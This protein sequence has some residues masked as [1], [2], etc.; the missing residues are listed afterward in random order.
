[1]C[2]DIRAGAKQIIPCDIFSREKILDTGELSAH[3]LHRRKRSVDGRVEGW[4][5][6][7]E[8]ANRFPEAAV[9][10]EAFVEERVKHQ[11]RL[12]VCV[13]VMVEE[14]GQNIRGRDRLP[15]ECEHLTD[16]HEHDGDVD[17][18]QEPKLR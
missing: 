4:R 12:P 2:L 14:R 17:S 18:S 9:I 1:M 6:P 3:R 5:V 7:A 10:P 13:G 15:F 11:G 8:Q 16:R